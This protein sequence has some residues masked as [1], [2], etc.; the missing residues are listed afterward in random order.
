MQRLN[1]AFYPTKEVHIGTTPWA[2]ATAS[3]F[4]VH[5]AHQHRQCAS[6]TIV[7]WGVRQC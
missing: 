2:A 3:H 6:C 5:A 1:G 7:G 4:L